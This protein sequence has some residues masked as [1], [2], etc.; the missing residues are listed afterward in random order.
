MCRHHFRKASFSKSFPSTLK[1]EVTPPPPPGLKSIFEKLRFRLEL[2]WTVGLTVELKL[3]FRII[4]LNRGVIHRKAPL[5]I[6]II[7]TNSRDVDKRTSCILRYSF[8][9]VVIFVICASDTCL[10]TLICWARTGKLSWTSAEY[11]RCIYDYPSPP[12]LFSCRKLLS[13]LREL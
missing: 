13:I 5:L 12:S 10:N 7:F 6:F 2:V 1:R 8:L 3:R 4:L 9:C 11:Q